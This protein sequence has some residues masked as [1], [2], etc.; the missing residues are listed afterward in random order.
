MDYEFKRKVYTFSEKIIESII[1]DF[2]GK[3]IGS[4]DVSFDIIMAK[5]SGKPIVQ[6]IIKEYIKEISDNEDN[7]DKEIIDQEIITDESLLNFERCDVFT[8]D[9]ISKIM[10][11][12]LTEN[13]KLLEPSVG[14]GQLLKFSD[15]YN[16]SQV[17]IYD[18]KQ[19]YLDK[20]PKHPNI[21]SYCQDFLKKQINHKYENI[22]LN[23]PYI[24]FQDLSE[25]YRQYIKE[26][27]PILDIGN[28]DI[29]Y[30]FLVKCL[31][32]LSDDG[33]MVA[34]IPNSYLTTNS[35]KLLRKYF[36]EN[37]YIS[38]IIDFKSDKVFNDVST[39]CCITVFT[40][41][42]K[43]KLHYRYKDRIELIN[44]DDISH[45]DYNIFI[46]KNNSGK[47][48]NDICKMKGGIATLRDKIYIH[49]DK[50]Y[51]EPCWQRITNSLE[52]SWVIFPYDENGKIILEDEFK[53]NNPKTYK[54]LLSNKE[55]LLKR[56]KGKQSKYPTWYCFGRTQSLIKETCEK[57]IYVSTF[58]DPNDIKYVTAKPQYHYGCISIDVID[59]NYTRGM[60]IDILE[61]NKQFLIDNT[62]K[63]GGG[64][65]NLSSGVLKKVPI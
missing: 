28:I 4:D 31:E 42:E 10:S 48:L 40:K 22:I 65:L 17:D 30:A 8:P 58:V 39:Y 14:D 43:T 2:N 51:N 27:W 33:V 5:L 59:E 56:D 41:Q 13:G 16:Y 55:E 9:D 50:L 19:E 61:K 53:K 7:I 36:I 20:C 47:T 32:V 37:K 3:I 62:T 6:P 35:A 21:N 24:R 29:Y 54:Y 34:I 45:N 49:S 25:D 57:V 12:Y 23:P 15:F 11:S 1:T 60:V 63:R 26:T 52:Q 64:W 44:Y 18:I 38:E 46:K